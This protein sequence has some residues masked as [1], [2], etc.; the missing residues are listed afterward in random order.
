MR[1]GGG[2]NALYLFTIK[3][4]G[5]LSSAAANPVAT[6]NHATGMVFDEVVQ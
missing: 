4:D 2:V 5:T 1:V 6:P 3:N